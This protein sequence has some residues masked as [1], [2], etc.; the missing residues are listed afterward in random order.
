MDMILAEATS[1][2]ALGLGA[3]LAAIGAGMVTMGA[4][5]GIGS[6]ASK[7]VE[8]MA[9]QPEAA[10]DINGAMVLTCAFIE[11]VAL[12]ATLA[13][14]LAQNGWLKTFAEVAGVSH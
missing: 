9:R 8:S 3:G 11:G 1:T 7:S 10:K 4:A 12:F 5:N 6:I 13:C 14:F 2:W